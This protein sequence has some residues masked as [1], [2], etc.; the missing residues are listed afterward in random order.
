MT[1]EEKVDKEKE[2]PG[3]EKNWISI[4]ITHGGDKKSFEYNI[5]TKI[6]KVLEDA[7]KA[8]GIIPAENTVYYLVYGSV[9]L[10]DE[11]KS[12]QDYNIPD[13]AVLA[14]ATRCKTG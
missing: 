9:N 12:L 5:H 4:T 1:E 7:L 6:K 2:A 11:N 13:G 10:D 3:K 8:L 14:L